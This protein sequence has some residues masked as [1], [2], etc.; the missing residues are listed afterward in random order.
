[1]F[2]VGGQALND[3]GFGTL[4]HKMRHNSDV[5]QGCAFSQSDFY[6]PFKHFLILS[7]RKYRPKV[8]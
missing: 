4:I 2:P 7:E 1:M 3:L 8:F 6:L 5:M